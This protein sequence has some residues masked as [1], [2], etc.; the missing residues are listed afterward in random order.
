MPQQEQHIGAPLRIE[1]L[2][3]VKGMNDILPHEAAL[4]EHLEDTVRSLARAYGYHNIRTPIVESTHLF[5]RGIGAVT[6]IVEKEM[7]S[8]TDALNG[9]PLTLR[10]ENTAAVVRA[11]IEHNLLYDGP[12]RLWYMGPM[13]R[14]ERPQRGRYRQFHQIGVEALGFAGPDADAEIILMCQR[15]W[16][17]LDLNGI[18]LELNSL[19]QSSERAAHRTELI[20][21]FEQHLDQLD[22][23]GKR[24]L[25]SNPLRILDTKNPALQQVVG[26]APK[27][28]DFLGAASIAH[29]EGLQA[30]LK[31][32]NIPFAINPRLVRGLDYYN[33]T[34]FEWVTDK[35]GAQGTVAGGGRYDPL[36]EQLGGKA[37]PACGWAMGIERI[38]EL[39]KV[40]GQ[41][42]QAESCD[43]YVAHQGEAARVQAGV[44]AERLRDAG[45]DVVVHCDTQGAAASF[46]AQMKRAD[47]SG[48]AYAVIIGEDEVAAGTASF[49]AL[50]TAA[51]QQCVAIDRLA[52]CLS[53]ALVAG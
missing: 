28:I 41:A 43:V 45:L 10:P 16:D 4:W 33:L 14:H 13:F 2:Q 19:G 52:E 17:D 51:P 22:E 1:K 20:R 15:L 24:R 40:Q 30:L 34:V 37:V 46:K 49:K 29:F 44:L 50:R 39:M 42:P 27:L 6:D 3:G 18:R 38:L 5:T 23:D 11:V 21:Y 8:F 47:A 31:A 35:L 53:N 9:E 26:N 12:K 7:Y 32:N 48:A 36:I 25:Y